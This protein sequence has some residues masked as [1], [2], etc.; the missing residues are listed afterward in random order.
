MVGKL[1]VLRKT[2]LAT[3]IVCL[4]S[5]FTVFSQEGFNCFSVVVGKLASADGSVLFAHNE[6]DYTPQIVNIY[7]VPRI[8]HQPKEFIRL[9]NGGRIPQVSQTW[10]YLWLEMPGMEFSDSFFNEWGV[11]IASDACGS[12]EKESEGEGAVGYELRCLMAARARSAKEAVML[13]GQLISE[14]GYLASGRSYII[15]DAREAWVMAVVRGKHWVAQRVPDDEVMVIPN[16]YTIGEVNLADTVNFLGSPDIIEYAVRKGWYDPADGSSFN[17]REAYGSERSNHHM[18]NIRRMWRGV[19]LLADREY[20]LEEPFPFSFKPRK[21]LT[22]ADLFAVLR[23]HYEGTRYDQTAGYLHGSPHHTEESTICADHTQ[24][25]FVAQL[26]EGMPTEIG[27]VL[28]LAPR[29]PCTMPAIPWYGGVSE[30]P[31]GFA[32]GNYDQAMMEHL[33]P[34]P[35]IHEIDLSLAYHRFNRFSEEMDKDYS[36]KIQLIH[37][38]WQAFEEEL[39]KN[40]SHFEKRMLAIYQ[41]N[42]EQAIRLLNE[43]TAD[44]CKEVFSLLKNMEL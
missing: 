4:I 36:E 29:R 10:S 30:I 14:H 11:V 26:R 28:W 1:F 27:A 8:Q 44:K 40:Q 21:K 6:D 7:R 2:F 12:R 31:Q 38:T 3:V 37:R 25:G 33:N 20:D 23:D 15:A 24:Y 16:Y 34:P 5:S 17:F 13:G 41:E 9:G 42:P 22:V 43:F 35:E 19:N 18:G 32:R 39:F